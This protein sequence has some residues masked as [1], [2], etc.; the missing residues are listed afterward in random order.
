MS[1][2]PE[3]SGKR[4]L[5]FSQWVK[6]KLPDSKTGFMVTDLDFI[7]YDYKRKKVAIVEVK[8]YNKIIDNW[9]D[10]VFRFLRDCIRNGKPDGWEFVGYFV[11]RFEKTN[12]SDGK[13]YMNG[14]ESS[15]EAI[16]K[17]LS[18]E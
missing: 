12:F 15:E 14:N 10:N 2:R 17:K 9:Q 5:E 18:F 4:S 13:V 6:D 16:R 7:L 8:Q 1:T 11:I 3:F